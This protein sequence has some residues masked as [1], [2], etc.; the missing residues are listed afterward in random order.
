[1]KRAHLVG[2]M[3]TSLAMAAP[4]SVVAAPIISAPFVTVGVGDTIAIEISIAD[5][6]DLIGW[7]F[8]LAFDPTIVSANSVTEGSFM[9]GFGTTLSPP[10]TFSPGVIA[11]GAIFGVTGFFNDL[12]PNPSG[13]GVLATIQ[14]TA[15]AAG[16][17]PLTFSNVFVNFEDLGFEVANGQITVTGPS[18]PVP[19]PA[20]LVLLSIGAAALGL[21][22]RTRHERQRPR[23]QNMTPRFLCRL[24]LVG[25][26]LFSADAAWAQ[27]V[28]PGPY[29]ATP[30]WD[31]TLPCTSPSTCPRFIVLSNFGGEAVLDR[32]TGLV[33]E[34]TPLGPDPMLVPPETGHR[35]WWQAR[36]HC[37]N[38]KE[39]GGR[40]GWR[41]PTVEELSS[42]VDPVNQDAF[43]RPLP[44]GHP[45][46]GIERE[47]YWSATTSA[48]SP[49]FAWRVSFVEGRVA[50]ANK[51][52]FFLNVWCV[53]G[54]QGVNPQ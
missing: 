38:R 29:Y 19:E 35:D 27:T 7:Q 21:R 51:T 30:S 36:D 33:W 22:R 24:G 1:M 23:R 31:Q 49:D 52:T 42:L 26:A 2:L 5:A 8:D 45:F 6:V 54:G 25:F 40:K 43:L 41:L 10:A 13:D 17:S 3:V 46:F 47:S 44:P 39:A 14:F 9:T 34:R 12:P 37:L 50:G 28:A 53:R 20:S 4:P 11:G 15:L 32:E 18:A 16:V 48:G